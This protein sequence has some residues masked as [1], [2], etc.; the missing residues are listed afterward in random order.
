MWPHQRSYLGGG[1]VSSGLGELCTMPLG[2]G[3]P[4]QRA[5]AHWL[6]SWLDDSSTAE[7]EEV[8]HPEPQTTDTEPKPKPKQKESEDG[9]GQTD[10]EEEGGPDRW[11]P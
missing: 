11:H 4:D 7:E 8:Q 5:W 9:A 2:G 6:V 10:L 1:E 3:S